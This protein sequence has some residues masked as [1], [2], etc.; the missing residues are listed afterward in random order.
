MVD[1]LI[2]VPVAVV[3]IGIGLA[4]IHFRTDKQEG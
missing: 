2:G 1:I 4:I 3:I